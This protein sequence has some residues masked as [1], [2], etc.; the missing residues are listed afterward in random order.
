MST[1]LSKIHRTN[2][3][4]CEPSKE[5]KQEV[6]F[7]ANK[8]LLFLPVYCTIVL[9][10]TDVILSESK[11]SKMEKSTDTRLLTASR[12]FLI[13]RIFAKKLVRMKMSKVLFQIGFLGKAKEKAA[14]ISP[15]F[16]LVSAFFELD[17]ILVL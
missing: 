5:A 16:W 10:V 11:P 3:V 17:H 7:P 12:F 8:K 14:S 9:K 2:S 4:L 15:R 13:S 1:A 6:S